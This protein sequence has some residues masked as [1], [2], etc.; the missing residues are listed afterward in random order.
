MSSA[1]AAILDRIVAANGSA[2]SLEFAGQAW[3]H[4]PRAYTATTQRT[5]AD[6]LNLLQERLLD[7]DASVLR[8][9]PAQ[10]P[11]TLGAALTAA[12]VHRIGIPPG[13]DAGL[14]PGGFDFVL[15]DALTTLELD[16]LDAV[17]TQCTLAIAETGTLVL[18]NTA[19]QGRRALTLVPDVHLCLVR[20][21]DIVETVPQAFAR[22]QPTATRPIT[23]VSGPSAT[24]DIEMTRVKGVHG[25][26]FL[27][28][29]LVED[30]A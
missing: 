1:R 18:Q 16:R 17:L 14:L 5:M 26:R 8:C 13:L 28:V 10:I 27:Y 25:P 24:A 6:V 4:L 15:D 19:G 20:S 21:S 29:V 9:A 30:Y 3:A 7:Y 22:L 23:F 11:A 12:H 2:S